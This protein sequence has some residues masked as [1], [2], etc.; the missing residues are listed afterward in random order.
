[1]QVN[2]SSNLDQVLQQL[3]LLEDKGQN[4]RPVMAEIANQLLNSTEDAF[5]NE[6]SPFGQ[7]WQPLAQATLKYKK[8]KPLYEEGRLQET[9]TATS[10]A[11]SATVG[12]NASSNGYPYPAVQHFGSDKVSARGFLPFNDDGDIPAVLRDDIL[13]ILTDHFAL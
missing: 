1:M 3:Q 2:I 4:L 6:T 9:T 10:D 5:E 11:S 12:T 13:E 7:P 8:G